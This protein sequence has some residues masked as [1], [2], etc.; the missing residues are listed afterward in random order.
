M[1][2]GRSIGEFLIQLGED[3]DLL[4]RYNDDP[5]AVLVEA[6]V[7]PEHHEAL[8]TGDLKRVRAALGEEYP[9]AEVFI[10]PLGQWITT[11]T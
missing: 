7:S 6:G 2:Q 8:L 1:E 9:E 10:V 3:Q 11:P 5:K 4:A